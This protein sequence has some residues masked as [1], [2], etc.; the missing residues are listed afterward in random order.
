MFLSVIGARQNWRTGPSKK[1]T[2][3]CRLYLNEKIFSGPFYVSHTSTPTPSDTSKILFNT[4]LLSHLPFNIFSCCPSLILFS[5]NQTR[6]YYDCC[7]C[8]WLLSLII[9]MIQFSINWSGVKNWNKICRLKIISQAFIIWFVHHKKKNIS[10]WNFHLKNNDHITFEFKHQ[11]ATT[12]TPLFNK[13]SFPFSM[14]FNPFHWFNN[15]FLPL[16]SRKMRLVL[17]LMI[18]LMIIMGRIINW[19]ILL[20]LLLK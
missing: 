2:P 19:K 13:F 7:C 3:V 20:P 5:N 11:A 4:I 9:I 8:C 12:R 15:Y 18:I 14:N 16:W 1:K 6:F 17:L 10:Q